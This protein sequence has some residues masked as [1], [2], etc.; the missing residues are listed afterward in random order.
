M[1]AA[2]AQADTDVWLDWLEAVLILDRSG[3]L[4][5]SLIQNGLKTAAD[6]ALYGSADGA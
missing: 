6:G 1:W 4:T 2:R 3:V 5:G